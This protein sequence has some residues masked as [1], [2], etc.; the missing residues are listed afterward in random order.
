MCSHA[1]A[2]LYAAQSQNMKK[3]NS[4][5]DMKQ[6]A[7][8]L[9]TSKP[10]EP[11]LMS[12]HSPESESLP[13]FDIESGTQI[14]PN[15]KEGSPK[16]LH[17]VLTTHNGSART[18]QDI[19]WD[20][21]NDNEWTSNRAHY[22]DKQFGNRRHDG[23]V[24]TPETCSH[25]WKNTDGTVWRR[26][27]SSMASPAILRNRNTNYT[28]EENDDIRTSNKTFLDNGDEE[29]YGYHITNNENLA[30]I[31]E[32]G[33][34]PR[35]PVD[36]ADKP[37]IYFGSSAKGAYNLLPMARARDA[38]VLRV[39]SEK[40]KSTS[41]WGQQ[42][43]EL[44]STSTIPAHHIEVLHSDNIWRPLKQPKMGMHISHITDRPSIARINSSGKDHDIHVEIAN[45]PSA[46]M[47]GLMHRTYLPWDSGMA[48]LFDSMTSDGFWMRNT[49]IPLSIAF[50]DSE[51][52]IIGIMDM[53]PNPDPLNAKVYK[54]NQ[55]YKGALEVNHGFF[56]FYNIKIGDTITVIE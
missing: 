25:V 33:L 23:E 52:V 17:H 10:K 13:H 42:Y 38:V 4:D 5:D 46:I 31:L 49:L 27:E 29:G 28:D 45:N 14:F 37:G 51:G 47:H 2:T 26:K 39:K 32:N 20:S 34:E 11:F 30:G 41:H 1:L 53:E 40:L 36:K 21:D 12:Q 6:W 44:S 35:A 18:H 8:E 43:G 3:A 50:W 48:F 54:P 56:D 16:E 9:S 7:E 19:H 22:H 55:L 15:Y 24:C